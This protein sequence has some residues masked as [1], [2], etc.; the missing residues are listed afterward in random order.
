MKK[1]YNEYFG[2]SNDTKYIRKDLTDRFMDLSGYM[3]QYLFY[4]MRELDN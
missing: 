2:S 1:V 4:Y 3:Q